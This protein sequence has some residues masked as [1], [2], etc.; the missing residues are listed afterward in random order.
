MFSSIA[1][2]RYF[3]AATTAAGEVFTWGSG[4]SGE[5]GLDGHSWVTTAREVE[6]VVRQVNLLA[7][8]YR[9]FVES[10]HLQRICM[11][12]DLVICAAPYPSAHQCAK[13]V[14]R[15]VCLAASV[16]SAAKPEP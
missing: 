5:L 6:G 8:G 9:S 3:S 14:A 2:S 15:P 12:A 11:C 4:F 10:A 16:M 13:L 1:A 7:Y